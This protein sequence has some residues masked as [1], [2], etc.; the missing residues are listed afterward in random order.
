[1]SILSDE[2]REK[3]LQ[4]AGELAD[5]AAATREQLRTGMFMIGMPLTIADATVTI[6][7]ELESLAFERGRAIAMLEQCDALDKATRNAQGGG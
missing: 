1:M 2:G 3:L 4:L 5:Q 7:Q 6:A